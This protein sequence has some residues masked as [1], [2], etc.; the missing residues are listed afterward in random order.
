MRRLSVFALGIVVVV[1]SGAGCQR[2]KKSPPAEGAGA[3]VT[4]DAASAG[5]PVTPAAVL[6]KLEGFR[7][8]ACA[9]V[10]PACVKDVEI[11]MRDWLLSEGP[12]MQGLQST[13]AQEE[14]AKRASSAMA[15]RVDKILHP[16]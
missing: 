7:D 13:P 8:A 2:S 12:A 4:L 3:P 16:R 6:A 14:A 1:A 15:A 10:E 5:A 11:A 9:C